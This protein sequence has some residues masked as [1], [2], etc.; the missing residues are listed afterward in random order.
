MKKTGLIGFLIILFSLTSHAQ[1]LYSKQNLSKASEKDL[2]LY[3]EKALKTT[4]TGAL[5]SVAG[6]A[7]F[8]TGILV[9][10]I[11]SSGGSEETYR[12]GLGLAFAGFC[13]S[14]IGLP[15][16]ISGTARIKKVTDAK[17]ALKVTTSVNLGPSTFYNYETQ[18]FQPGIRLRIVF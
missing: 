1:G 3:L 10:G 5:F 18:N 13:S 2:E 4:R 17:N 12:F 15:I 7:S 8:V 16:L 14:V 11:R 9:A 6:S